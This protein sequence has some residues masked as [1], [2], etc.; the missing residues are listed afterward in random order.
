MNDTFARLPEIYG[1]SSRPVISFEVF[2]PKTDAAYDNLREILP[3]L[4]A[5]SPDYMTVTYGAMGS[6]RDRTLEIARM[7]QSTLKRPTAT[8]LTCVGSARAGID[9]LLKEIQHAGLRNIVALRGDPPQ[10]QTQFVQ[11][12]DGFLHAN[13]LVGHIR[14]TCGDAFGL[15]VAGYPEKHIEAPDFET[16]LANL[17][18]KVDA[19]ADCVITQLFYDNARYF[20][21]V[22]AARRIGITVPI[23]PGLLPIVSAKQVVRITAMCGSSLPQALRLELESVGEDACKGEEIGIRQAVSQA[24]DLLSRGAP[25]IHF[26]VLNKASHMRQI[27]KQINR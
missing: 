21:F 4:S 7:I 2:P 19:G 27:M 14:S 24:N 15:A 26:Y 11:E 20:S 8:H 13:E 25:G 3:E 23:V 5:L 17:K 1:A 10:G 12:A 22:E 16:D 6:T 9:L 18:R